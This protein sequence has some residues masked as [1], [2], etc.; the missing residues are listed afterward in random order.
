MIKHVQTSP[1]SR[2]RP[3]LPR[4][5]EAVIGQGLSH[6]QKVS[7]QS[8]EGITFR[9]GVRTVILLSTNVPHGKFKLDI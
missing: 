9:L 8:I 2:T 5:S 6:D 3:L 7:H 4:D 1:R